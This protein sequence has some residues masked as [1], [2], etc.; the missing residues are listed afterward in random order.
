MGKKVEQDEVNEL[1]LQT[2]EWRNGNR[3]GTVLHNW[4]EADDNDHDALSSY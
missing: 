4:K 1:S 3:S 2:S